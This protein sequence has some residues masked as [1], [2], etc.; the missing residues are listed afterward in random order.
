MSTAAGLG[1]RRSEATLTPYSPTPSVP[2]PPLRR[3]LRRSLGGGAPLAW[4]REEEFL[5]NCAIAFRSVRFATK[6]R[7]PLLRAH[8]AFRL[9]PPLVLEASGTR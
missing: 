9:G 3:D 2:V 8:R 5:G 4:L 1:P 7:V 6:M